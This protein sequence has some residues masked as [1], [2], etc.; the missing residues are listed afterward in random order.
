MGEVIPLYQE[1]DEEHHVTGV[2]FCLG[3]RKEWIC[4]AP[5]GTVDGLECPHCQA[6][7]GMFRYQCEREEPHWEC[8][9]GNMYM[10]ATTERLYCPNCGT[11]QEPWK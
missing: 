9:C 11:D 2:A 10:L 5:T 7:K 1:L 4:T 6:M 3:C 8:R